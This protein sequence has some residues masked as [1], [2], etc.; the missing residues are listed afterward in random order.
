MS[1]TAFDEYAE[2]YDSWFLKN[3]IVLLSEVALLAS[4]LKN[5]GRTLSVGCGSGLF[6]MLL[7]RDHKINIEEGLEPSVSMAEIA[8]KR[9]MTVKIGTAENLNEYAVNQFDTVI[10]NG[11]PSYISDLKKAF[12]ETRRILKTGGH[13]L[14]LDVP[15]ESGYALLYNFASHLG[16]W[17]HPLLDGV[18]PAFPYPIEFA[19]SA[20]WR[21]TPEKV[22]LLQKIGFNN[23]QFAQTLTKHPVYTHLEV[24]PP[25]EGYDRGGYVAIWAEKKRED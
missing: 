3:E 21:T 20:N 18:R 22:A 12:Q 2:K 1:N 19:K 23:F 6:E 15:K 5:P 4:F 16:H 11:S 9:G 17:E 13:I 25:I 10:F 8:Q 24:E 14:V 7:K